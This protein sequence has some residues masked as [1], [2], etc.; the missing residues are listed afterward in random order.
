M[1]L[2]VCYL[3]L[4]LLAVVS[5]ARRGGG[6]R[7]GGSR[8]GSRS[9]SS[10]RSGSSGGGPRITRTTPI[11]P[12]TRS[13]PVIRS[14][15]SL[16]TRSGVSPTRLLGGYLLLRYSLSRGP[17]Y[18]S[19]YPMNHSNVDMIIPEDRAFRVNYTEEFL[20]DVNGSSCLRTNKTVELTK[21]KDPSVV[22]RLYYQGN[23]SVEEVFGDDMNITLSEELDKSVKL[24]QVVKY[25]TNI[26]ANTNCSQIKTVLNG[27][28]VLMYLYNPD[29]A[30]SLH[31]NLVLF[32]VAML[33][34]ISV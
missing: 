14:Q 10:S 33:L 25:N 20:L 18:R 13:T 5:E 2:K 16:K 12:K 27:T 3:F 4:L 1:Y 22:T 11:A 23:S 15:T 7:S 8:G 31:I 28:V 19:A 6:G 29:T 21:G 32:L 30:S 26:V 9:R 34:N 17:I 24:V